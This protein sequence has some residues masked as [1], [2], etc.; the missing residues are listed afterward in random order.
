M[1]WCDAVNEGAATYMYAHTRLPLCVWCDVYPSPSYIISC[2]RW[3]CSMRPGCAPSCHKAFKRYTMKCICVNYI[4]SHSTALHSFIAYFLHAITL[5]FCDLPKCPLMTVVML[6][7]SSSQDY[8]STIASL[9]DQV[10]IANQR[11]A[12]LQQELTQRL[13]HPPSPHHPHSHT[14]SP[15]LLH[16]PTRPFSLSNSWTHVHTWLYSW[17]VPCV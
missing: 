2:H 5:C 9:R 8:E 11:A 15:S 12:L 10:H 6:W 1:Q 3:S 7:T 13:Q 17:P 4:A 14:H 16:T